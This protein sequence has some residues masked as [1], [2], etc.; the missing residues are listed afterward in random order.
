V[1]DRPMKF[2]TFHLFHRFEGQTTQEVYDY[3]IEVA[4]LC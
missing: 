3:Q 2:S 1:A 4:E